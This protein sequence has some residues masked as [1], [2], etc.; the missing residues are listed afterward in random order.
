VV[1]KDGEDFAR[2]LPTRNYFRPN[3]EPTGPISS[4]FTGEATSE[5]GLKSGLGSDLWTAL[6]PDLT[7]V[8]RSAAQADRGF[9]AC[10]RG[11]PGTPI[12]C[13]KLATLMQASAQDPRL[14]PAALGLINRLQATTINRVADGYLD[15][16][17]PATF[18]VN[19][20]PMVIWLFIG[21]LIGLTGALIAVWPT[22]GARRRRV[23]GAAAA[24]LGRGLS[25]A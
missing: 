6:Q 2:L 13:R 21:G 18:R 12:G 5:V 1:R 24:R 3:G 15:A 10:I 9:A 4:Y 23:T 22:P 11:A 8:Q 7:E 20:N 19:V 14:R 25:R 16:G 17:A